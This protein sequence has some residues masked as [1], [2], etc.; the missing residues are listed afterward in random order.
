MELTPLQL[1]VET[2]RDNHERTEWR[3]FTDSQSA[4]KAINSPHQQSGQAIIKDFLDYIDDINDKYPHLR[5]KRIWI[6][7]HTMIDGNERADAEA[8]K[9]ATHPSTSRPYNHKPLKSARIR[10]IK[11]TARKQWDK[12]WNENT[13]TAKA[14]RRIIKRK[15]VKTGPKLYNEIPGRDTVAKIVQPRTGHCGLNHYLH[16]FSK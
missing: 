3:I 12:E 9:A 13:K 6:P 11:E 4:I 8:K 1:V 5:I 10:I 7:G 16:R 14:L 2:L 15:G